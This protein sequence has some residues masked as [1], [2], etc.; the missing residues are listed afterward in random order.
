M[1]QY[2]HDEFDDVPEDGPRQGAHRGVR[3]TVRVGARELTAIVLAGVLTLG[4]GVF[5]FLNAP[6]EAA[7]APGATS[8]GS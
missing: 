3:P 5:A 8:T 4:V 2:P 7:P 1:T 6:G